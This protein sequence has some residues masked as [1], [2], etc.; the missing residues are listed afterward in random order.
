MHVANALPIHSACACPVHDLRVAYLRES[1]H[2]PKCCNLSEVTCFLIPCVA[3]AFAYAQQPLCKP[4]PLL[5]QHI[6]VMALCPRLPSHLF[7]Q[8]IAPLCH[9]VTILGH[10]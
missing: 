3:T 2:L 10:S 1:M 7:A 5:G 8:G 6:R 9:L 4:S